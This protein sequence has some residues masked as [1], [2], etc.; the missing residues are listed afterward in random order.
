MQ[1]SE[2][3]LNTE[4]TQ[5]DA[6]QAVLASCQRH[7]RPEFLNRLDELVIFNPLRKEELREVARMLSKELG[8]RLAQRNVTM[9]VSDNALDFAVTQSYDHMYGARPLR[10][11]LVRFLSSMLRTQPTPTL[12]ARMAYEYQIPCYRSEVCVLVYP[13]RLRFIHSCLEISC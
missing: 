3:L 8:Q 1:G 13:W 6:R 12:R 11:W 7:F 5:Q 9:Q 2:Y 4:S 10:R